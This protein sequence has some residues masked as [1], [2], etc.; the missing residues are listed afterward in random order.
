VL[1]GVLLTII[2]AALEL[3]AKKAGSIS[4]AVG[5]GALGVAAAVFGRFDDAPGLILFGILLVGSACAL[6][7]RRAQPTR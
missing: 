4:L 6:G 2:G 1:A 5:V 7:L 3:A